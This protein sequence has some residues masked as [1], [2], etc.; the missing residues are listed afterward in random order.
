MQFHSSAFQQQLTTILNNKNKEYELQKRLILINRACVCMNGVCLYEVCMCGTVSVSIWLC[1]LQWKYNQS[2]LH[3]PLMWVP[4]KQFKCPFFS[5]GKKDIIHAG[6]K[7]ADS[8]IL[9]HFLFLLSYPS[10]PLFINYW[11]VLNSSNIIVLNSNDIWSN[12]MSA[13]HIIEL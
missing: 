8:F 9:N 3:I 1:A 2:G 10:S 4:N 5:Q 13:R 11:R 6:C 7:T 12:Q